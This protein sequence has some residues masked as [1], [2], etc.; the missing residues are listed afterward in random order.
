MACRVIRP[1]RSVSVCRLASS[2]AAITQNSVWR[3]IVEAHTRTLTELAALPALCERLQQELQATRVA[4]SEHQ[5]RV[6]V[7]NSERPK[8]SVVEANT[9][10][11]TS[12][13]LTF[14]ARPVN[15]VSPFRLPTLAKFGKRSLVSNPPSPARYRSVR[16][17]KECISTNSS[18][19]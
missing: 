16:R 17:E 18:K 15:R 3:Q 19:R 1:L 2:L 7:P 13:T 14:S 6:S 8:L 11:R 9:E 5:H 4:N 10:H 12:V